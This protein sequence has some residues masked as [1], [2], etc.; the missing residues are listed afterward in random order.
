M[1]P[2]SLTEYTF[3]DKQT[4]NWI[5]YN[6]LIGIKQLK[7]IENIYKI[8]V[9]QKISNMWYYEKR[10]KI[11]WTKDCLEKNKESFEDGAT[12]FEYSFNDKRMD[13]R[14]IALFSI[15]WLF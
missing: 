4:K 6:V 5:I 14:K 1:A 9:A 12:I 8:K 3:N 11:N 7:F 2:Q 15:L 10:M 13:G